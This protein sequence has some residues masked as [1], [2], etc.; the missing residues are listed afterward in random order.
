M[1]RWCGT[2]RATSRSPRCSGVTPFKFARRSC[3]SP[4]ARWSAPRRVPGWTLPG[5]LNAGAAQ[6]ALKSAGAVPAD[7]SCW[8][9]AALCS[10]WWPVSCS[11][12][13]RRS[14]RSSRLR[15]PPTVRRRCRTCR[16]RCD[17]PALLA[18]GLRMLWRL[19]NEQACQC[20]RHASDLRSRRRGQRAEPQ[21]PSLSAA[22][23]IGSSR[24]R[25]AASRRRAQHPGQP[26][27]ARGARWDDA[28]L[29]W[30]PRV[31]AWG[32]T[33]LAGLRI[34]GD[35]AFIAGALAAE[36]SG[37]IA[38][39]GA[40]LTLRHAG[41]TRNATSGRAV[42]RRALSRQL[43]IRPFLD[44]LVPPA[45]VDRRRADDT[46]VCRCEEVTAGRVREMARLGCEGPNQTKFFSRCG[47]G[48]CQGRMCGLT[49]TQL[50]A[51]TSAR[52]PAAGGRLSHSSAAE[53][54]DTRLV[55]RVGG[56]H[57]WETRGHLMSEIRR[58]HTTA[59]MSKAVVHDNVLY[60]C[61]QT[62][63]GSNSAT[64]DVTGTKQRSTRA[65]RSAAGRGGKR[66]TRLL[67]TTIY[68]RDMS[69]FAAMNSAWELWRAE[70]QAEAPARATVQAAPATDGLRVE[71][72]V[73][74]A[75]N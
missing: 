45:G 30:Q 9:A 57:T 1:A 26:A 32:Q 14:R 12:P 55:R 16:A 24:C 75:T 73:V 36:A 8:S 18:K 22:R 42:A 2:W 72:V 17:A 40:A 6:I 10:C 44:A 29:A 41:R 35:A 34:A 23:H 67:M 50:L 47:M 52:T 3:W 46:I 69:D 53:A 37:A 15:P 58:H 56:P 7:P 60:L 68:L 11:R 66:R 20:S 38:A 64:G 4:T 39:I 48:P 59:R 13:A 25:T 62:A 74:A 21:C 5:V 70:K 19:R 63:K 49:V 51:K 33:S 54:S 27:A 43:R 65:N 61:G 31:D 28:Q 71:I